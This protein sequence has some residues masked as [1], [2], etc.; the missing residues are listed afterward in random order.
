[1]SPTDVYL[2]R[3]RSFRVDPYGV[4]TADGVLILNTT[5][6]NVLVPAG[7]WTLCL[8]EAVDIQWT[9]PPSEPDPVGVAGD[10]DKPFGIP[11]A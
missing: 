3:G 7:Q 9:E 2:I 5:D 6:G 4:S 1:M 8:P 11:F 10:A